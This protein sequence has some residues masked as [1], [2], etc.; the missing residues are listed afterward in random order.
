M[1][2]CKLTK[3]PKEFNVKCRKPGLEW[4]KKNKEGRKDYWS[5]FRKDL[6]NSFLNRCAYTAILDLN[7]TI[8]HYISF[9]NNRKLAFEWTNY[10][11]ASG[12]I[13]SSKRTE[14]TKILDPLDIKEDWFEIILPSLQLII[15]DK[16]PKR[17]K[18]KAEYTLIRLHLRDG[19]RVIQ[20]RQVWL[21]EYQKGNITLDALGYYAPLVAKA[22]KKQLTI[23]K[24]RE[25]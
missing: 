9:E 1:I 3:E 2:P 20:Q 8:D 19:E 17:I 23:S 22:V 15:T 16:M 11:Y 13:N 10:R 18:A 4:L 5:P 25:F 14:D 21:T 12:W 24:K 6:A 7:G